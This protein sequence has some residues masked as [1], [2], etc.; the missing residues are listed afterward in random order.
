MLYIKVPPYC[1]SKHLSLNLK[2]M[3]HNL[4]ESLLSHNL[5]A[6]K[7][8]SKHGFILNGIINHEAYF[9]IQMSH[10]SDIGTETLKLKPKA[11]QSYV[12]LMT[13]FINCRAHLD[14]YFPERRTKVKF[15]QI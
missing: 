10:L 1:S 2:Y 13:Q 15:C 9:P 3:T 8:V 12:Q 11:N 4:R 14:V 6:K 7:S 5:K